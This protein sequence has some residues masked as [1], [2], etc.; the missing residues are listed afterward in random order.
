[1]NAACVALASEGR[2]VG[3]ALSLA[4]HTLQDL[5]LTR[6]MARRIATTSACR[7]GIAERVGDDG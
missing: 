7:A 4:E 6:S 2:E 1:L 5:A 3:D